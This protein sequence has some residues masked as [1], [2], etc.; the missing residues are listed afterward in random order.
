MAPSRS[1]IPLRYQSVCQH[2]APTQVSRGSSTLARQVS[3]S[4]ATSSQIPSPLEMAQT[5]STAA[6]GRIPSSAAKE[7][8]PTFTPRTI[9]L[10][11][12]YP[13]AQ[14]KCDPAWISTSARCKISRTSFSQVRSTSAQREIPATTASLAMRSAT[15]SAVAMGT[16]PS[17]A[18][19]ARISS[20]AELAQTPSSAELATIPMSSMPRQTQTAQSR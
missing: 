2:L 16:T 11:K 9:A 18:W 5:P 4:Q 12:A 3:R 15:H 20:Q 19:M 14:M 6:P 17:S 8:T 1:P 10:W 7:M 13:K